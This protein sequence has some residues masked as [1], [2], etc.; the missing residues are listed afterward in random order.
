M[1]GVA[2]LDIN[3]PV[4]RH[5]VGPLAHLVADEPTHVETLEMSW[6][7]FDLGTSEVTE[8]DNDGGHFTSLPGHRYLVILRTADVSGLQR[9]TL[10]GSGNFRCATDVDRN[11]ISYEAA[12]P[13]PASIPHLE[14]G[15]TG[16]ARTAQDLFVVMKPDIG[17]FDYFKLSCGFHHFNGTPHNLEYFAFSGLMTFSATGANSRGDR[18]TA[19][20]TTSS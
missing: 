17:A 14:F 5:I 6:A 3:R 7:V 16:K 8:F 15:N 18:R 2:D 10:D 12:L 13:L 9:I 20:L 19:S 11:G 1:P 4:L